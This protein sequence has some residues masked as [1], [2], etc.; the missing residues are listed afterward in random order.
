LKDG[1]ALT[2]LNMT[3]EFYDALLTEAGSKLKWFCDSCETVWTNKKS[4]SVEMDC[5]PEKMM[6][7]QAF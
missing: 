4:L 6:L 5:K 3:C 7:M 1:S 2:V